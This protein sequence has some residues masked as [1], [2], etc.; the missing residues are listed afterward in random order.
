MHTS[1]AVIIPPASVAC[2]VLQLSVFQE[3]KQKI[4]RRLVICRKLLLAPGKLVSSCF[5][6]SN[7]SNM[8]PSE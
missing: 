8:K 1:C 7:S 5:G 3:Y 4:R 6:K 2:S